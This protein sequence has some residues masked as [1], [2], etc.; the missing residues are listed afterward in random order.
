MP[1]IPP[2]PD[3]YKKFRTGA[4]SGYADIK[5]SPPPAVVKIAK[6]MLKKP[7]G[8]QEKRTID[9]QEYLFQLEPQYHA[10]PA[11]P[12]GWHKGCSAYIKK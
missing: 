5:G 11:K 7:M 3:E 10:P 2:M 9:E 12:T 6:E 8:A 1:P 4:P